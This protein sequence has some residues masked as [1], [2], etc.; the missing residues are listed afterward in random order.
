MGAESP[1]KASCQLVTWSELLKIP[2]SLRSSSACSYRKCSSRSTMLRLNLGA[3]TDSSFSKRLLRIET[4]FGSI[5]NWYSFKPYFLLIIRC[6]FLNSSSFSGTSG[7]TMSVPFRRIPSPDFALLL[8]RSLSTSRWSPRNSL[9]DCCPR[10]VVACATIW[11]FDLPGNRFNYPIKFQQPMPY[12]MIAAFRRVDYY[13]VH[14]TL[15]LR[16]QRLSDSAEFFCWSELS[17]PRGF[18]LGRGMTRF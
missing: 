3:R 16:F 6:V 17:W 13:L 9:N 14:P 4:G 18:R 11:F 5:F 12:F 10:S 1:R 15:L 7:P 8:L 2:G